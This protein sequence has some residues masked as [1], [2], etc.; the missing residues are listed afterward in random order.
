MRYEE[1]SQP[2]NN[3]QR[4]SYTTSQVPQSPRYQ[5]TSL[6]QPVPQTRVMNSSH[7]S[8]SPDFT[9][10]FVTTGRPLIRP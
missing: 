1:L 7:I 5:T 8:R 9:S 3:L 6:G 4:V 2:V 10:R